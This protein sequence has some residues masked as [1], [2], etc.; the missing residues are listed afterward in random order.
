[1]KGFFKKT[2]AA[3]LAAA[4]LVSCAA[5][6]AGAESSSLAAETLDVPV[7]ILSSGSGITPYSA[8]DSRIN[9]DISKSY[10]KNIDN[11]R[12]KDNSTSVYAF[13][14]ATLNDV[15]PIYAQVWGCTKSGDSKY[16]WSKNETL[17]QNFDRVS[18]VKLYV[19]T[20]YV[21]YNSVYEDGY[22]FAG[23][24]LKS[25]GQNCHVMGYWSPDSVNTDGMSVAN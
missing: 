23:L 17:N 25:T 9:H 11:P 4:M 18:H 7:K 16:S 21:I 22:G 8:E 1:M 24:K 13:I 19:G 6:T 2:A 12:R 15:S 20:Q 3:V 5:I 10:F 14:T